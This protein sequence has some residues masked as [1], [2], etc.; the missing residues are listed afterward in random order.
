MLQNVTDQGVNEWGTRL[1]IDLS[2]IWNS[3]ELFG[4]QALCLSFLL[5]YF[6]LYDKAGIYILAVPPPWGG[7][8]ILSKLKYREEFEIRKDGPRKS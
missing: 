4:W 8:E 1:A 2:R 5:L 6:W 3:P 7:G